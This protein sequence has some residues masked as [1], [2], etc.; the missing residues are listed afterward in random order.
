MKIKENHL[1]R[2]G[3]CKYTKK[4]LELKHIKYLHDTNKNHYDS[5]VQ[6]N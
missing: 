6:T 1:K 3:H 4:L 5:N 2:L